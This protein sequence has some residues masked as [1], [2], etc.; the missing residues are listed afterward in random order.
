MAILKKDS[1]QFSTGRQIDTPGGILSITRTLELSDYYS[2][3]IFFYNPASKADKQL[4]P[5]R[6]VY[7]LSRDE[8]IETADCMIRLWI[9]LKDNIRKLGPDNP[10]IFNIKP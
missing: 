5:V 4:A 2:R 7:D 6:N 10:D 9:D 8:L 1:V 3:N